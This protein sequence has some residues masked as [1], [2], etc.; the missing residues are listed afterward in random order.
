MANYLKH[1]GLESLVETEEDT[2]ALMQYIAKKGHPIVG[3]YGLPY[4]NHHF[5]EA[6]FILRTA[7]SEEVNGLEIVGMDVHVSGN[8]IWEV[9][10]SGMDINREDA[11]VTEQRCVV[12]NKDDGSGMVVV[13]LVN[14]DV[15]PG[16]TAGEIVKLQMIA[17]PL[18]INY[19]K[20]E[21][22][23]A[24][25]RG[26]TI[27]GRTLLLDDGTMMPAGLMK[28]RNPESDDFETDEALDDV[29]LIRG[30]VKQ[31]FHGTV[32]LDG[33]ECN[34]FIKCI[35]STH[36]GD[37]EIVHT[38]DEIKEEQQDNIKVGAVVFG[39][40][41]LSGDP[42]IF[43]YEDGAIFD[44]EHNIAVLRSTFA[45][46]DAERLRYALAENVEYIAEYNNKTY[47]GRD[48]VVERLNY[49]S[50]NS[51]EECFAEIATVYSVD[52]GE[53]DLPYGV[54]KRCIV[55]SYDEKTNYSAIAFTENDKDGRITKLVT[56]VNSRYHFEIDEDSEP[57]SD[58]DGIEVPE[59]A[60]EAMINRAYYHGIIEDGI[61]A[62]MVLQQM[63]T[64]NADNSGLRQLLETVTEEDG[65]DVLER[66]FGY[67]FAKAIEEA[68]LENRS[69]GLLK[70]KPTVAYSVEDA[71]NGVISS[72]LKA[73]QQERLESAMKL[74]QQFA[75]DFLLIHMIREMKGEVPRED[76]PEAL[77]FVRQLGRLYAPK[78]LL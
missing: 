50:K 10:I 74:G 42:A 25:V 11:D 1:L 14:A 21:D 38:F 73:E 75:K 28:N 62:D 60:F 63:E 55:L 78:C 76:L 67:L 30:T 49:V 58:F 20:N 5:G 45:G 9:R 29:M 68:Y 51:Q 66:F 47:S 39:A 65:E 52:E 70:K 6:Q 33:K 56:S 17:F 23:Y 4:L 24:A 12:Q 19:Y 44:E 26:E 37:L 53:E 18:D 7:R 31:L 41:V 48:A 43:E 35:I 34:T 16:F 32:E 27:G 59:S 36:F 13:N 54:G 57:V 72:H 2:V 64:V 22:A 15:L 8:A 40:F 71:R 77:M 46:A 69:T 3:Y 61:T